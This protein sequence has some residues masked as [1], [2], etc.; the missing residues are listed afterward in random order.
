M[1]RILVLTAGYGEGHHSAARHVNE[2]LNDAADV[3]AEVHDPFLV[4]GARYDRSRRS[5]LDTVA[6]APRLWGLTYRAFDLLPLERL[7]TPFLSAAVRRLE[8]LLK[9][10]DAD[11]AVC[12]YP[13]HARLARRAARNLGK[14]LRIVTLVTDSITINRVWAATDADT[15]LAPDRYSAATL[16]RQGVCARRIH[17]TGF[18]VPTRLADD[19]APTRAA[20]FSPDAPDAKVLL[21]AGSLPTGSVATALAL[22]KIPRVRLTVLTGRDDLLGESVRSALLAAGHRATVLGWTDRL[23]ELL[24]EHHIALGKAGGATTH[25]AL[26]ARTPLVITRVLPGQEEGN[27]R[28]LERLGAGLRARGP[29]DAAAAVTRML[30]DDAHEW[31]RRVASISRRTHRDGAR[32]AAER[33]LAD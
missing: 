6:R 25:E 18:P 9:K 7:A 21:M 20:P 3:V 27:V 1:R 30:D 4:Y 2:A 29:E 15:Y 5:Y 33:I 17:A 11:T 13:I 12:T 24:R 8:Y 26:A 32:R 28:L 23:P 31:K 14:K 16:R 19:S 10:T 22:A